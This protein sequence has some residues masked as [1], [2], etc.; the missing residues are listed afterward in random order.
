MVVEGACLLV[1]L[2]GRLRGRGTGLVGV[3]KEVPAAAGHELSLSAVQC[4][5]QT[6]PGMLEEDGLARPVVDVEEL[7]MLIGE[8]G[9]DLVD[10]NVECAGQLRVLQHTYSPV[11]KPEN[12]PSR[13]VAVRKNTQVFR[14]FR[15]PP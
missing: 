9:G 7:K 1:F 15:P 11:V 5:S 2:I 14:V 10:D 3:L 12:L 4:E 13:V 6:P 8:L